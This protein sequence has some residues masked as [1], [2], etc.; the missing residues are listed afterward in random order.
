MNAAC[1]A[2]C[3][4]LAAQASVAAADARR[5][6]DAARGEA[7]YGRCMA[8]H[9]LAYNRT[10]PRHCGL[11]GRLARS[12][13]AFAYAPAMVASKL[14]WND[15]TPDRFLENPTRMVPGTTMGYAGIPDAQERA[16][17]I[18]WLRLATASPTRCPPPG[19]AV[20]PLRELR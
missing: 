7:I 4:L 9:A 6:G 1:A 20:V 14:I 13:P 2:A 3:L 5:A 11:F 10:G 16:D 17:L 19:H 15:A 18:A 12:V 8:C